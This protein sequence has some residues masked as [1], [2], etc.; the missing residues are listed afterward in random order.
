M[1]SN[2]GPVQTNKNNNN[3]AISTY[4]SIGYSIFHFI[5]TMIAIYLSF[6]RNDGF[7]FGAFILAFCCPYLY[8]MYAFA[9]PV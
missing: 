5:I 7:S 6:K 9:V 4:T 8:L 2:S 1:N 3:S